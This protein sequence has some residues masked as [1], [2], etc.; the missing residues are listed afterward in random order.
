MAR[1]KAAAEAA[2]PNILLADTA[3]AGQAV[4][5]R[6]EAEGCR[7]HRAQDNRAQ[8]LLRLAAADAGCT[9]SRVKWAVWEREKRVRSCFA[10][11]RDLV[12]LPGTTG[13]RPLCHVPAGPGLFRAH[14]G[15]AHV[16]ISDLP[17]S[18]SCRSLPTL[19]T[20]AG[21]VRGDVGIRLPNVELSQTSD[22]GFLPSRYAEQGGCA[23][24]ERRLSRR[25]RS[26]VGCTY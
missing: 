8:S 12:W 14:R 17:E 20:T 16:P 7:S 5:T 9:H 2:V 11:R 25:H 1:R 21:S 19:P 22:A 13:S 4:R 15:C 10:W 6:E 18:G 26:I 23:V 24:C 3:G